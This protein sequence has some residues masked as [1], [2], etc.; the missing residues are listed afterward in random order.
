LR[1]P[2]FGSV[3]CVVVAAAAAAAAGGLS[4]AFAC[5]GR[6]GVFVF[7]LA[8]GGCTSSYSGLPL[9]LAC[10][11]FAGLGCG[12]LLGEILVVCGVFVLEEDLGLVAAQPVVHTVWVANGKVLFAERRLGGCEADGAALLEGLVEARLVEDLVV[13]EEVLV[14]VVGGHVAGRMLAEVYALDGVL[15]QVSA[16][17][18]WCLGLQAGERLQRLL[19]RLR[20]VQLVGLYRV[21]LRCD[22]PVCDVIP[23]RLQLLLDELRVW[24][25][26]EGRHGCVGGGQLA[27]VVAQA[28]VD[29]RLAVELE[30]H[31]EHL[32]VVLLQAA[33]RAHGLPLGLDEGV[34]LRHGV[35][36]L[37]AHLAV[38]SPFAR[39]SWALQKGS[40][41]VVPP[42]PLDGP[43]CRIAAGVC[44]GR[45]LDCLRVHRGRFSHGVWCC[46]EGAV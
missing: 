45:I 28:G 5:L 15:G 31:V 12:G 41:R 25:S 9:H 42:R 21:L 19:H 23:Q 33:R 32:V 29:A 10:V 18:V 2:A 14:F 1:A 40:R 7:V 20:A 24:P 44:W 26:F 13:G 27:Q 4:P 3:G 35:V 46:G 6:G 11:G 16:R 30:E 36:E 8:R 38:L 22:P 37:Y 17:G 39:I 43:P 34:A